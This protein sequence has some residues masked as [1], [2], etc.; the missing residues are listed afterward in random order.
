MRGTSEIDDTAGGVQSEPESVPT[1]AAASAPAAAR[2]ADRPLWL[3]SLLAA[4][5]AWVLAHVLVLAMQDY[6]ERRDPPFAAQMPGRDQIHHVFDALFTWD[7]AWYS[8]I[9]EH[10]YT[11]VPSDGIRFWPLLPLTI[12]SF[13][14]VGIGA[15]TGALVVCWAASLAFGMLMYRVAL[16]VGGDEPTARRAAWLSQLAPG[17]FVLVMGYT[18]A[19]AGMLAAAFLASIL[20]TRPGAL[21]TARA[22][23]TWYAVGFVAGVGSGLVRPTGWLL[24]L[25]G[26]VEVVGNRRDRPSGTA[27]RLAVA[28]SPVVGLLIFLGWVNAEY[29]DWMLPYSTQRAANLRGTTAA[30]PFD[31]ALQSINQGGNGA[32][33]FTLLLVIASIGLL[34]GSAKRLPVSFTVWAFAGLAAV[35]TAPHFS[36]FARYSAGILPLLLVAAML[37]TKRTAWWWTIGSSA[38]LCAYFAFQAFIGI[39]IP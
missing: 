23:W 14:L 36:S 30:N 33:A 7:T 28:A 3:A 39:Y 9:A 4:L 31:S 27:A 37:T 20:L 12:R 18:E 22:T 13:D 1:R 6:A 15:L 38:A 21:P 34:W 8:G 17:A 24:C 29:H 11:G 25:A 26:L 10:G 19:L 5:P 16:A 2:R 35:I 32:G